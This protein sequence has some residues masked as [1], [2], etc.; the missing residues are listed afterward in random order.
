ML[1][2]VRMV[3]NNYK[4]MVA[5]MGTLVLFS[6]HPE[7]KGSV[8]VDIPTVHHAVSHP[9]EQ[10][11]TLYLTFDDG[12][13]SGSQI[14]NQLSQKDSLQINVFL[15]GRN[16]FLNNKNRDLFRNYQV[17]PLIELGNHSYTHAERHYRRYFKD[18]AGVLADFNRN[19][20]SLK[21]DNNFVRLPGRNFFR[22]DTLSRDDISNG[23]EAADMLANKGYEVF[24]WDLEWRRQPGKGVGV[25][26]GAEMM[27]IVEKML[28]NK[29]TFLPG[30]LILLLH[31]NELRNEDFRKELEDFIQ[32][33]K[34]AGKFNFQH[35]SAYPARP[36]STHLLTSE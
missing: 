1:K 15:V 22:M 35:L 28:E 32:R 20:D 9:A 21:L 30:H 12:P 13:S 8:P 4:K 23:K 26:T 31:D 19:R 36:S 16:V 10:Q 33:A 5:C 24:G 11:Y 17:N 14:V 3:E 27:D 25:H 29:K 2:H 34:A 7:R 6:F 18:P